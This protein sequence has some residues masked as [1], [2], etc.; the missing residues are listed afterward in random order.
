MKKRFKT[1]S[2][3]RFKVLIFIFLLI[4]SFYYT[5]TILLQDSF[6][7][8]K[9]II[10]SSLSYV[11]K[12]DNIF[13]FLK[14]KITNPKNIV[15]SVLNKMVGYEDITVFNEGYDLYYNFDESKSEYVEETN[16]KYKNVKDPVVYI[17]NTHQLEEYSVNA[18]NEYSISPNVM[19]ASFML[20]EELN[21]LGIK[22]IVETSNI[23]KYL[24]TN[25]MNYYQSYDASRYY[26]KKSLNKYNSIEYIIDI[27]R[28][29]IK[30]DQSIVSY[31][32]D[33]YAR[34]LFV[35]G[36]GNKNSKYNVTLA[37]TLDKK[38][39]S[40]IKNISRGIIKYKGDETNAVYNQDLSK[41]AFLIEI[42]GVDNTIDEVNNTVKLLSK[43][44]YEIIKEE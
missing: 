23:K 33:N 13:S 2:R 6:I 3:K 8:K 24:N 20:K 40:K 25:K 38:F 12:D 36:L 27:H 18:N 16:Q 5:L 32:N 14:E 19:I 34:V 15:Y 28:D 10:G 30:K 44:L 21:S 4:T 43:I 1:K 37:E 26:I 9:M 35:V 42:G 31:K 29:S 41:N 22:T 7:P 11:T 17:Y 39:N